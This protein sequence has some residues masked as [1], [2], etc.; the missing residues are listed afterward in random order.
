MRYLSLPVCPGVSQSVQKLEE[1]LE[2]VRL[3]FVRLER[4]QK[5]NAD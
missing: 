4:K 5:G 1:L 2:V 3:T